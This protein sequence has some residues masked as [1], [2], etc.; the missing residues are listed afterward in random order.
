MLLFLLLFTPN[1]SSK[2]FYL[3]KLNFILLRS[4]RHLWWAATWH[5]FAEYILP[6][7][8][9]CQCQVRQKAHWLSIKSPLSVF[10]PFHSYSSS[11]PNLFSSSSPLCCCNLFFFMEKREKTAESA[12][13][14]G[15]YLTFFLH[16]ITFFFFYVMIS[17]LNIDHGNGKYGCIGTNSTAYLDLEDW[18]LV[19]GS[20]VMIK[21]GLESVT[22][23]C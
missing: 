16:D 11:T 12:T 20:F 19:D 23:A 9:T 1:N 14:Q 2:F 4:A 6:G 13:F 3:I 10:I 8:M 5:H 22:T 17:T 18:M 21:Q 7:P 15:T